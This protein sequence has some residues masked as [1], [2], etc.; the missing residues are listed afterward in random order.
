MT[1]MSK[2][3]IGIIGAACPPTDDVTIRMNGACVMAAD[4]DL[5]IRAFRGYGLSEFS[6]F[7][8]GSATPTCQG[9]IRFNCAGRVG[10]DGYL[11]VFAIGCVEL[12]I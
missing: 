4:G 11:F 8:G 6:I 1:D 5:Y 7:V 12:S 3:I 10:P 9:V 2:A